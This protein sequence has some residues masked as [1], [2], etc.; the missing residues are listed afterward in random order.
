MIHRF[1]VLA[2]LLFMMV[3]ALSKWR[4][5]DVCTNEPW[6]DDTPSRMHV[7]GGR[8]PLFKLDEL[9]PYVDTSW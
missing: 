4:I 8:I 2:S 3:P 5:S 9:L 6:I 1:F 7:G